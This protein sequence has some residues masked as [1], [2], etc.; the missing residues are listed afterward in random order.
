MKPKEWTGERLETFVHTANTIEHLHRYALACS[1]ANGK[2]VVDVACGEGYGS[3]LLS[4]LA[5]QVTGVDIAP[6]VIGAAQKKYQRQNLTFQVGAAHQLPLKENSVDLVVSF[7]TIEHHDKHEEMLTEIRRVLKSGGV[8]MMSSP[9]K[10]YYTDVPGY[11]NS[12]HVKEL[13]E[14]EFKELIGCY[15]KH[16]QFYAQRVVS[17]SL[18]LPQEKGGDFEMFSGSYESFSQTAG[19]AQDYWICLASDAALPALSCS[20]FD[21]SYVNEL[22]I[23]ETEQRLTGSLSYRLGNMLLKPL[24]LLGLKRG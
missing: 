14:H 13:Y 24:R 20:L 8:L 19:L 7:E 17:G 23:R 12:F 11:H 15:F 6:E 9:D 2:Q 3:A 22:R 5:G 4:G 18:I 21:G 1:I 10:H 16:A